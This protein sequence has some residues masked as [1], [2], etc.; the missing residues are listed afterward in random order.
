M[1][2]GEAS[3]F[4]I[5]LLIGARTIIKSVQK[6]ISLTKQQQNFLLSTTHE[7]KTPIASVKLLLETLKKHEIERDKRNEL[8]D[9][10]AVEIDRLNALV[11]NILTAGQLENTN[12]KFD[13]SKTNISELT[14]ETIDRIKQTNNHHFHAEIQPNIEINSNATVFSSILINLVDN[15]IKYSDPLS[16]ITVRLTKEKSVLLEVTDEG[17]GI[18]LENRQLIFNKFYRSENEETRKTKGTGLGLYIVKQL[19][20]MHNARIVVKDNSPK[21][22]T[23]VIQF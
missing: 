21:G 11:E 6:E 18:P 1:V 7:L 9:H 23:F 10:A 5:I 17:N 2:I 3:V 12:F 20:E 14:K 15:A 19:V 4:L 8:I 22:T 16:K 13:L